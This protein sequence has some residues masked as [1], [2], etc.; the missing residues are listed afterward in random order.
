MA[1]VSTSAPSEDDLR[2]EKLRK[3]GQE[4]FERVLSQASK[5]KDPFQQQQAQPQRALASARSIEVRS[6]A[7]GG[8]QK[9]LPQIDEDLE[10]VG[11]VLEG[12]KL[13]VLSALHVGGTA[14]SLVLAKVGLEPADV[15]QSVCHSRFFTLLVTATSSKQ[16]G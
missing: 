2:K 13:Y 5:G 9:G 7:S 10:T 15:L 1:S 4:Y 14:L 11:A 16:A 3:A 8:R 6:L 12:S